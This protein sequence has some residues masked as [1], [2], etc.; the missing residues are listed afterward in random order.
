MIK[1]NSTI[2]KVHD[3]T[4]QCTYRN[5]AVYEVAERTSS[6]TRKSCWWNILGHYTKLMV[7]IISTV[8][9][10][11]KDLIVMPNKVADKAKCT[12]QI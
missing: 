12:M 8:Y 9:K 5:R 7:K 1:V 3:K 10:I 6:Y 2:F 4:Y 11:T